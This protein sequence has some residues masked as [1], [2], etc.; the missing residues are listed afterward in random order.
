MNLIFKRLFV[1]TLLSWCSSTLFAQEKNNSTF[2]VLTANRSSVEPYIKALEKANFNCYHLKKNRRKLTF[3]TGVEIELF[4]L[5]E[6]FGK[7]VKFDGACAADE[8]KL[9]KAPV[10]HLSESGMIVE[11]HDDIQSLKKHQTK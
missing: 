1:F 2:S 9:S 11:L 6:M 10:Y 8:N 7:G 3:D 5:A 4:S